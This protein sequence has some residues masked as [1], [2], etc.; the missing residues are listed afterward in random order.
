M[1]VEIGRLLTGEQPFNG[2]FQIL[3]IDKLP[4]NYHSEVV[5]C[6]HSGVYSF[7]LW[8]RRLYGC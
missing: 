7:P 1:D 3:A 4:A 5:A 6:A 8:G 2:R